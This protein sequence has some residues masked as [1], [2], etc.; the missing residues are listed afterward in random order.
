M[1]RFNRNRVLNSL[2]STAVLDDGSSHQLVASAALTINLRTTG[3]IVPYATL[4]AGIVSTGGDTPS[5]TL[6][7]NYQFLLAA[8]TPINETDS[9]TVRTASDNNS[10]AGILSAGVKYRVSPRWGIRL[11]VRVSLSKNDATTVL[12][13]AP[14]VTIGLQPAGF[15]SLGGDPSIQFS[16][17]TAPVT[18][19]GVTAVAG[20]SLTA[21]AISGFRTFSGSGVVS[22]T[23]LV[24]GLPW[25][26]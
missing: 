23:N 21:P 15:G 20:S 10:V 3:A 2:T 5:T 6:R 24:A 9:V 18:S 13:A 17:S 7:G 26:F 1:V 25:R 16:N 8:G 12:D 14:S 11:G 22:H 19:L 4:G